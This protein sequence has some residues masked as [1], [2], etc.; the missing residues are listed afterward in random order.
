MSARPGRIDALLELDLD[1]PRDVTS[2]SFN[3]YKRFI[4]SRLRG[5]VASLPRAPISATEPVL[6]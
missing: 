6:S 2:P 1:R 4:L 3:D 5:E